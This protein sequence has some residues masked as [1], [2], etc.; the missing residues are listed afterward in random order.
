MLGVKVCAWSSGVAV[1]WVEETL[2]VAGS[3]ASSSREEA[4]VNGGEEVLFFS[5]CERAMYA[6][7]SREARRR[8]S[9]TIT[10][11]RTPM[12]EPATCLCF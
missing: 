7:Y 10:S 5:W 3:F 9:R 4:A 6:S 11:R 8:A 1:A 2:V 12:Q